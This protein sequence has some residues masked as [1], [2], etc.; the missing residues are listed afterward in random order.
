MSKWIEWAIVIACVVDVLAVW[1]VAEA[2][3]FT[4]RLCG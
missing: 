3:L 4:A 2:L 1:W